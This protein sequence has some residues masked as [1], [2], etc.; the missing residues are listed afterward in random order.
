MSFIVMKLKPKNYL[1]TIKVMYAK[2]LKFLVF[3]N[4]PSYKCVY[5]YC[6]KTLP[7]Y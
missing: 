5:Y 3:E 4:R 2:C 1:I 7:H 6:R